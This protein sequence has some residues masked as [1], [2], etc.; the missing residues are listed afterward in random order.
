MKAALRSIDL[1]VWVIDNDGT[2]VVI[3]EVN[4]RKLTNNNMEDSPSTIFSSIQ[5]WSEIPNRTLCMHSRFGGTEGPC[6]ICK[7]SVECWVAFIGP[8]K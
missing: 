6:L 7:E 5:R 4:A 2:S 8:E 1:E 3:T